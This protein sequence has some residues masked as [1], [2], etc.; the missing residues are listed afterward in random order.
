MRSTLL[1]CI[2]GIVHTCDVVAGKAQV[3]NFARTKSSILVNKRRNVFMSWWLFRTRFWFVFAYSSYISANHWPVW[4][5]T[6]ELH[7]TSI[8]CFVTRWLLVMM[9]RWVSSQNFV[10]GSFE[11]RMNL[12]HTVGVIADWDGWSVQF[13]FI[14]KEF[15]WT[16]LVYF[17]WDIRNSF[18]NPFCFTN[19]L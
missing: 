16:T 7:W 2:V 14:D 1:H 13:A 3:H 6:R 8:S 19:E 11:R 18:G 4:R 15:C 17:Q 12:H 10:E 5:C 9:R